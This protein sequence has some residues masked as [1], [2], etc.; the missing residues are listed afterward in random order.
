VL[1][2]PA[3]KVVVAHGRAV[4]KLLDNAE[5]QLAELAR[6]E[7]SRRAGTALWGAVPRPA[8]G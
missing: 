6:R 1:V 2:T 3:G 5:A 4:L 8:E 7:R